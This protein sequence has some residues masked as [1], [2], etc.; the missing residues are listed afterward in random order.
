MTK[1][2][3]NRF[4]I[5]R[6]T[7][8][9][10][11]ILFMFGSK[12][13]PPMFGLSNGG[14]QVLGT[15]IGGVLLLLID[16]G[17]SVALIFF[18]LCIIPELGMTTVLTSSLG[19]STIFFFIFC[20]A[21][22]WI[23]AE[24]G[25]AKRIAI[26]LMT[27]KIGRKGPWWTITM[28]FAA[29]FLVACFLSS[30]LSFMIFLPIIYK[31]FEAVGCKQEEDS[32]FT[33]LLI[34][35]VV[36]CVCVAQCATPIAHTI[37]IF[38]MNSYQNYTGEIMD[39]GTYV[40]I[41]M[42]VAVLVVTAWCLIA[43]FLWNPDVSLLESLDHDI[44]AEECGPM[45]KG[46]K[47]TAG[48]YV[49]VLLGW[50]VP[51]FSRYLSPE[52]YANLFSKIGDAYPPLIGLLVL[53]FF[54]DENKKHIINYGDAMKSVSLNTIMYLA[55]VLALSAA[56]SSKEIGISD[57]MA[58]TLGTFFNGVSPIVFTVLIVTGCILLTNF[59]P[60]M[61]VVTLGISIAMPVVSTMYAGQISPLMVAALITAAGSY[62]YAT[63]SS[64]PTAAVACGTGWI[65]QGL[66]FKWGMVSAVTAIVFSCLVGI[67]I[68]ILL[69]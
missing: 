68:G 17:W 49:L 12:L 46:E 44:L 35:G 21:F 52:L 24:R 26:G 38:G 34:A 62:A 37:T 2:N 16:T 66:L 59:I 36:I 39:F 13:V 56:V 45:G 53:C 8:I 41:C 30:T 31:I 55:A 60:N 29:C 67:P 18:S 14:F 28:L 58:S 51:G 48:V 54:R 11:S 15:L 57:W 50:I 22:S 20:F 33:S 47:I 32:E 69:G 43:R 19:S 3:E 23:L 64:C 10:C 63:P 5:G 7:L 9:I 42:P 40:L 27:S 65:K 4:A 1:T 6:T 61:V 25:I